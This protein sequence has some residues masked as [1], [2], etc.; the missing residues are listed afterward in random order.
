MSYLS[1]NQCLLQHTKS[2]LHLVE[3]IVE[4]IIQQPLDGSI[5]YS[6]TN[7]SIILFHHNEPNCSFSL[8]IIGSIQQDLHSPSGLTLSLCINENHQIME[9]YDHHQIVNGLNAKAFKIINHHYL[10]HVQ[11]KAICNPYFII[12]TQI[13]TD[14][15]E[16]Y[17]LTK[18]SLTSL[19]FLTN[20]TE[21]DFYH[22][23]YKTQRFG[24]I[25]SEKL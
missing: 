12:I 25:M 10:S 16:I 14:V 1:T 6:I 13:F 18:L 24:H 20:F 21:T 17:G 5:N 9:Y 2:F 23:T 8:I 22:H 19:V 7:A 15:P 3:L 11:W 4:K